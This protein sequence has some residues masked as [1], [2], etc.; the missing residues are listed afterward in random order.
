MPQANIYDTP[1]FK[2]FQKYSKNPAKRI[3]DVIRPV[4]KKVDHTKDWGAITK[5][6]VQ[7]LLQPSVISWSDWQLRLELDLIV[8]TVLCKIPW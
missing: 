6:T 8:N 7:H 3:V 4:T 2:K 5:N 1:H